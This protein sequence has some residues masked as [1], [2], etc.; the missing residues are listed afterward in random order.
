LNWTDNESSKNSFCFN[1]TE[2]INGVILEAP[3]LNISQ[4]C[5]DY[6]V[7]KLLLNNDWIKK[8][9]DEALEKLNI[10]FNNDKK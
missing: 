10:H 3:F 6:H 8:T 5:K 4:A 9:G 7:G 2:K 1:L